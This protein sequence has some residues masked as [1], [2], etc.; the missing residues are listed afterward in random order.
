MKKRVPRFPSVST[1]PS[2]DEAWRETS[3]QYGA[4][5]AGAAAASAPAVLTPAV[6]P[7][8]ESPLRKPTGGAAHLTADER[9]EIQVVHL[10][11]GLNQSQLASQFGRTRE[12][13]AKCLRGD[14][15]DAL[16][17]QV[18]ETVAQE[19]R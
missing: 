18:Q 9:R 6:V 16:K 7:Q 19:A 5:H 15:F 12:A 13:I 1:L 4:G 10:E 2:A 3:V 17:Q 11:Q 14:D 8:L